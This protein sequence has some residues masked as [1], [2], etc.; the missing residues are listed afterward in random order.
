MAAAVERKSL[1][2]SFAY[3]ITIVS[4]NRMCFR[5]TR[6]LAGAAFTWPAVFYKKSG[7]NRFIRNE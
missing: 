2:I 4:R 7:R 3:A 5:K 1:A 6:A